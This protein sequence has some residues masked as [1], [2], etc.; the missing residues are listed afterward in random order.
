MTKP[1]KN[2]SRERDVTQPLAKL[3]SNEALKARS[4]ALRGTI[5]QSLADPITGAIS[6]DD[7]KLVKFHG[8]Y[9]QDDRDVREERRRQ[10]LEPDYQF[11]VR[12]RLPGGVLST[13]QW[14]ALDGIAR[15]YG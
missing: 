12:V 11:M 15:D 8:M 2:P 4:R 5:E 3:D 13:E 7:A 1:A 6:E 9:L 10:K 14:L